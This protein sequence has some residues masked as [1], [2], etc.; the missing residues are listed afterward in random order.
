[1]TSFSQPCHIGAVGRPLPHRLAIA[2][3]VCTC[4]VLITAECTRGETELLTQIYVL[5]EIGTLA[6]QHANHFI[7]TQPLIWPKHE[8][9]QSLAP[10]LWN[11]LPPFHTL[12]IIWQAKCLF[13]FAQYR[14][15]L[16][17]SLALEALLI[18]VHCKKCYIKSVIYWSKQ[19]TNINNIHRQCRTISIS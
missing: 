5:V 11:Q 10:A 7:S 19:K 8:P 16:S 13:S 12:L 18:G 3:I 4:C 9:L 17:G 6:V 14:S 15:L 2:S 1:V